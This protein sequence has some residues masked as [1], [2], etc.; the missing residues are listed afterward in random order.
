MRDR[1][2]AGAK[3]GMAAWPKI[4]PEQINAVREALET[5]GEADAEI[6]ARTFHRGRAGSVAPLLEALAGLGMA[7]MTDGGRYAS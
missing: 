7:E 3:T 5:L 2:A 1:R 6:I 4:L